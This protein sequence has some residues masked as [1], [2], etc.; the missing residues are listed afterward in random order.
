MNKMI[1]NKISAKVPIFL[2]LRMSSK[3]SYRYSGI[4]RDVV[5]PAKNGT[6][7]ADG[8]PG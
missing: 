6:G 3:N 2:P 1:F 4:C 5:Y 7:S 8:S